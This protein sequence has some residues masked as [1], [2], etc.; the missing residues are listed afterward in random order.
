ME[1]PGEVSSVT[2]SSGPVVLFERSPGKDMGLPAAT[3]GVGCWKRADCGFAWG[4]LSPSAAKAQAPRVS[5]THG[6]CQLWALVEVPM[7][8]GPSGSTLAHPAA[9][10]ASS[11][12][13]CCLG[14]QAAPTFACS[15][16]QPQ[17]RAIK[18]YFL[19]YIHSAILR[20]KVGEKKKTTTKESMLAFNS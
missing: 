6:N 1:K 13:E 11:F 20:R 4:S 10:I 9:L 17:S 18:I 12:S 5:S 7:P 19:L 15:C 2:S 8:P 3:E 14:S 16:A